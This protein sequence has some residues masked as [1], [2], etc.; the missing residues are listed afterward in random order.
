MHK[1]STTITS[2][3]KQHNL[4]KLDRADTNVK[5]CF[6]EVMVSL[7]QKSARENYF[8]LLEKISNL[9]KMTD[10]IMKIFFL[11]K[12]PIHLLI[13]NLSYGIFMET[14]LISSNSEIYDDENYTVG[15]PRYLTLRRT[16][17]RY[18]SSKS[19]S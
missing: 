5:N 12:V 13:Y 6:A 16:N 10:I 17:R 14:L 8:A 3:F 11:S 19:K 15:L 4:D 9:I 18:P 2:L 7:S 1:S